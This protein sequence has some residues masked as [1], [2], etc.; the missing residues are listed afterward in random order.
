MLGRLACA[1][2]SYEVPG[3]QP[4]ILNG[5]QTRCMPRRDLSG[6]S[7]CGD[8]CVL[9]APG[10]PCGVPVLGRLACAPDSSGV[11][12][13]QPDILYGRQPLCMPRRELRTPEEPE[14]QPEFGRASELRRAAS[15]AEERNRRLKS[16]PPHAATRAGD[17]GGVR[18]TA[19]VWA[20]IGTP[21]GS[22][23]G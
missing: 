15:A 19:R 7:Y 20:S 16:P 9:E 5:F 22:P 3:L 11:P 1:S 21:Q 2:D 8:R 14:A 6:E 13:S 4:G 18:S 17:P 10:L 12:G 23:G